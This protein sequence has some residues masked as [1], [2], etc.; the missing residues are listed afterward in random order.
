MPTCL[1]A[2]ATFLPDALGA[3]G[4]IPAT[5]YILAP[6]QPPA[7]AVQTCAFVLVDGV[8]AV[9]I[10]QASMPFDYAL[11]ASFWVF[12]FSFTVGAWFLAKNLGLILEGIKRW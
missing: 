1:I 10:Q 12:A 7:V 6:L 3:K 8:E 5:V 2:Q 9:A 11:A 4:V